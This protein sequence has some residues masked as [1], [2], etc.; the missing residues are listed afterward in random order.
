MYVSILTILFYLKKS[1]M[2]PFWGGEASGMVKEKGMEA[3]EHY[4]KLK[5]YI[6]QLRRGQS[7]PF[8]IC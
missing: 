8:A 2:P 1:D 7:I 3:I 5:M 6:F 4:L